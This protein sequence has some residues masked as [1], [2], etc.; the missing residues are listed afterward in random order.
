MFERCIGTNNC[1]GW[2]QF[3]HIQMHPEESVYHAAKWRY[4]PSKFH[5][6]SIV[7]VCGVRMG[8]DKLTHFF[9]DGF[10]YFNALR[11]KSK[12]F[13]PED[14]RQLSMAFEKSYM[15][16]RLTGIVSRADIEANLAG[17]RFYSDIFIGPSPM[18]GRDTDGQIHLL[19]QPDICDYVTVQFDERV[20]LNDFVYGLL[21]STHAR[22]RSQNL[23]EVI[24]Q[25]SKQSATLVRDLSMEQLIL[26]KKSILTRHI[27]MTQWQKDFP[28]LRMIGHAGGFVSHWLFD[29]GLRRASS[30][31]SINPLK[32]GK[33]GDRKPVT[34]HRKATL[35][36]DAS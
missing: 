7:D 2:P 6:A 26:Q 23:L 32:P 3:E 25:R 33:L 35:I 12:D 21:D 28:K 20:L 30:L 5:L 1:T 36:A 18:I 29:P 11:S 22:E 15:G 24:S 17:V 27:P 4:I 9:D 10:H 19:R 31:F 34:I 16:A 8:A 13:D 14:I